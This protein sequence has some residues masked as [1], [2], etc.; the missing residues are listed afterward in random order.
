[1]CEVHCIILMKELYTEGECIVVTLGLPF[2]RVLVVAD[3]FT[4]PVPAF[5][6]LFCLN[7]TIHQ[8]LHPVIVKGVRLEQV[9]NV[10]TVGTPW[11]RVLHAEIVPLGVPTSAIVWLQYQVIFE[12]INLDSAT[13][14]AR[15]NP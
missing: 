9:N 12:L 6:K 1:M 7:L 8:G 4:V 2:H 15:L 10:E 11:S 5:S 14:V 3:I 13:K